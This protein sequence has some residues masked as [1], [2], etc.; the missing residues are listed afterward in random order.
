MLCRFCRPKVQI[1][2][3]RVHSL[4]RS[5]H[6]PRLLTWILPQ[7]REQLC[8]MWCFWLRKLHSTGSVYHMSKRLLLE[9]QLQLCLLR[10]PL[11]GMWEWNQ[12]QKMQKRR[13]HVLWY[14]SLSKNRNLQLLPWWMQV[15]CFLW[16]LYLLQ[17]RLCPKWLPMHHMLNHWSW[18]QNL[19]WVNNPMRLL[20]T[21]TIS[22]E[23]RMLGMQF[24]LR[25]L[26]WWF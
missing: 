24:R 4:Q 3:C 17:E 2:S 19:W 25:D 1:L 14:L 7:R 9:K 12:M 21:W 18:L 26:Y 13:W 8:W 16:I 20:R 6:L 11:R 10:L 15:L 23:Q 5:W 22:S